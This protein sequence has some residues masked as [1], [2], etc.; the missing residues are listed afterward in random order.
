MRKTC[1]MRAIVAGLV[2]LAASQTIAQPLVFTAESLEGLVINADRVW[3]AEII[4]VRDEPIPGGSTMPGITIEIEETLKYPLFE[5]RHDKM[6]LFV[7]PPTARFKAFE[8]RSSRLL[9]AQRDDDPFSPTLIELSPGKPEVFLADFT[10]LR[11]PDA[12]VQAAREV[13]NRSAPNVR[14]LQTFRLMIPADVLADAN[15]GPYGQ[16]VVPVDEHLEKRA[17]GFLEAKSH[18]RRSEA[19]RALRYFKSDANI[20]RLQALLDDAGYSERVADGGTRV[21][22][23]GV[24]DDAY[25][26]LKAWDVPV[27]RPEIEE[28]DSH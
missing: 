7:E 10:I 26:T 1:R 3:I 9:I 2:L 19:A 27:E 20:D 24:R 14:Q 11:Q 21:K 18:L 16:L 12:V 4:K 5:Q 8:E 23:Y 22:Y 17:I 6:G 25:R 15:L 13:I 28:R